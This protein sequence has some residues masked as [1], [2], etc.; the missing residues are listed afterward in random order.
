MD[1]PIDFS[2]IQ[3]QVLNNNHDTSLFNCGD[4]DINDFLRNEA[5]GWQEKKIAVT[6]VFIS[7]K[8]I[9]GFYC[10]S[11]DSIKLEQEEKQNESNLDKKRIKEYPA[12]KI[13][14]LGVSV[15]YQKKGLGRFI[16]L[17]AIGHIEENLSKNIGVR[18]VTVDSYPDRI[19]WYE[20][21]GFKRN[22]HKQYSNTEN[23]SIRYC[24]YNPSK[25]I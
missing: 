9:V 15:R 20:R 21:Q 4:A 5:L 12:I 10:S 19:P 8:E 22:L 25:N 16:L 3:V 11:A 13:G 1:S 18:F 24:L 14:R 2:Q 7:S 6:R 17:W 23:V